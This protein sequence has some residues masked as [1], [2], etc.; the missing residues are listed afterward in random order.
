MKREKETRWFFVF[1]PLHLV[2]FVQKE[3]E[4]AKSEQERSY[5]ERTFFFV[6]GQNGESSVE[7]NVIKYVCAIFHMYVATRVIN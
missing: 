1:F 2:H 7:S 5:K 6:V 3:V 4:L